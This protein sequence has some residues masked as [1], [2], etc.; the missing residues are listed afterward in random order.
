MAVYW[1]GAALRHALE[2]GSLSPDYVCVGGKVK[3]IFLGKAP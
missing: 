1:E 3:K 2:V